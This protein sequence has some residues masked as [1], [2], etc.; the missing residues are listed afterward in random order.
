[1]VASREYPHTPACP[2]AACPPVLGVFPPPSAQMLC[3][4]TALWLDRSQSAAAKSLARQC[5]A[6]PWVTASESARPRPRQVPGRSHAPAASRRPRPPI[7]GL[8]L[9]TCGIN[10]AEHP[11][12]PAS[13][14]ASLSPA[15]PPIPT[16]PLHPLRHPS[17]RRWAGDVFMIDCADP[18]DMIGR[19]KE[20]GAGGKKSTKHDDGEDADEHVEGED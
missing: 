9:H 3:D 12:G 1:M 7:R 2:S 13:L 17:L 5:A 10:L 19:G 6:S 4:A 8:E 16:P 11:P 20:A 14:C 18:K 15:A